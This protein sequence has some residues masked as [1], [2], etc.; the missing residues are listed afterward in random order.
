[1]LLQGG[2]GLPQSDA[3][4]WGAGSSFLDCALTRLW[5]SLQRIGVSR[6]FG[7]LS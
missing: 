4:G 3:A 5:S 2:P 1:M 7:E 6:S